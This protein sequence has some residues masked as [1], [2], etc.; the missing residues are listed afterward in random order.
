[1]GIITINETYLNERVKIFAKYE[2]DSYDLSTGPLSEEVRIKPGGPAFAAGQDLKKNANLVRNNFNTR[3]TQ[4]NQQS[5][6][7][8]NGLTSLLDNS[9]KIETLNT[10]SAEDFGYY[11]EESAS[12]GGNSAGGGG[13]ASGG[14][15]NSRSGGSSNTGQH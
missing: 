6:F 9:E 2:S 5:G 8:R 13:G 11:V 3:A 15:G 14:G 7:L 10:M 1:M 12:G 4:F